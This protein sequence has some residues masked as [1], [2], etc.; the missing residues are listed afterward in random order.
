MYKIFI[1]ELAHDDLENIVSYISIDLE[2]PSAAANF[3][4]EVEK[5]YNYLKNNPS[6]YE[7]CN[8][9]IL[10]KESY[11]KIT[12]KNYVLIYKIDESKSVVIIYRI[13]YGGQDYLRLI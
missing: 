3:L 2:N 12:I 9:S 11:R 5:C 7:K 4:N 13:F 10:Q 8:D 6:M 1:S